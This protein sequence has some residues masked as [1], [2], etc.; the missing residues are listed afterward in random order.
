MT[1]PGNEADADEFHTVTQGNYTPAPLQGAYA[2]TM[3]HAG[4]P[5]WVNVNN[6]AYKGSVLQ[7]TDQARL[8]E[9][10][11]DSIYGLATINLLLRQESQ[12]AHNYAAKNRA[13]RTGPVVD[14]VDIDAL[15]EGPNA[16]YTNM[17]DLVADKSL[18]GS[19][20]NHILGLTV[21]GFDV[22]TTIWALMKCQT[23]TSPRRL[24]FL[25]SLHV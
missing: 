2:E 14:G 6:K 25:H 3:Y 7:P 8:P 16:S 24:E 18:V 17:I 11:F 4:V 19:P 23:V 12:A 13:D 1:L 22:L 5:T 20:A 10:V 9:T 15:K 21:Q